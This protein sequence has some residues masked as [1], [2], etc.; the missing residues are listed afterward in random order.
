MENSYS[1]YK[2][3]L[4]SRY[5]SK[6]MQFLFSDQFKFSTWRRLWIILAQ[7]EKEIGLSITDDQIEEMK[8]AVNDVAFEAAAAEEK[9]TRHDVMAHVHVF[10]KQC[11]KAAPIIHLGATSC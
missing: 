10:A 5:A 11:P 6:E 3:P 4:S 7:A 2:S 1:S 9:A 8:S